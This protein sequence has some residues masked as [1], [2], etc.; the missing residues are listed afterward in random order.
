M[1][2]NLQI[3]PLG[4][5]FQDYRQDIPGDSFNWGPVIEADKVRYF[6]F[7][8][9]VTNQTAKNDGNWKAECDVIANEHLAEGWEGVGYR[10]IICSDGTTA[11]VGDLS[12]GGSAVAGNNDII[13]SVCLVGDFTKELPTA[14]QIDS[15][16]KLQN[17]FVNNMPQYP[18]I[19]SRDA[20]IGHKDAAELL[21]LA[22]ATPT[23]CPGPAWRDP[24]DSLR[25]RILNNNFN[26][27]PD[28]QPEG[29]SQPEQPQTPTQPIQP[30]TPQ[31]PVTLS[32]AEVTPNTEAPAQP[33]EPTP[34]VETPV[35]Q[36][37]Q[38]ETPIDN[39]PVDPIQNQTTENSV[40]S[41]PDVP[42]T[43]IEPSSP[44]ESEAQEVVAA[45][46]DCLGCKTI[47]HI[48]HSFF[49][50]HKVE[51]Q[52]DLKKIKEVLGL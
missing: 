14:A 40:P 4:D 8:H 12:H 52:N 16:H 20:I 15:A 36:P 22:G 21:H 19:D 46:C 32:P 3:P 9:S 47:L 7:H 17:W 48:L 44:E 26:G 27:Y 11:Y 23:A 13:F 37:V 42:T 10:F 1:E 34:P 35:E 24:N 31:E 38:T 41:T 5:K 30:E 18:L 51:L 29:V 45:I 49:S 25:D 33:T 50:S 39:Q 28:P 6:A 43:P 2:V